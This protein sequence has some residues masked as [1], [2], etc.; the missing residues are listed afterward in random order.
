MIDLIE[1][2]LPVQET[3]NCVVARLFSSILDTPKYIQRLLY[4]SSRSK[5]ILG[6]GEMW[7]DKYGKPVLQNRC[8]NLVCA[9]EARNGTID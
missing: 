9:S 6:H 2:F 4:R 7:P 8:K 5:S 1:S 3:E